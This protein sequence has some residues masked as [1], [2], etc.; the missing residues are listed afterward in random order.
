VS[1][2][3]DT[4]LDQG[5]VEVW[6]SQWSHEI[7]RV[8]IDDSND[9]MTMNFDMSMDFNADV[10]IQTPSDARSFDDIQADIESLMSPAL[11]SSGSI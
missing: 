7:T 6:V 4:T 2:E 10:D 9:D 1:D 11:S 8:V 5:R 3:I